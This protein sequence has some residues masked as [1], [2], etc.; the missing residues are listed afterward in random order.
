MTFQD[1][2]NNF[3]TI[4]MQK[5]FCFEGRSGR[6]EFWMW[7][8]ALLLID[9]VYNVIILKLFPG[10]GLYLGRIFELVI[11]CPSLG[12][13]ARRLH[14]TGKTGLLQLIGLVFPIGV[15]IILILCAFEGDKG[16]NAYGAPVGN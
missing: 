3:K 4:F 5:Y 14:D 7:V 8:L 10:L 2:V 12:V 16:S 6:R 1:L 15:I 13:T 11:L 9:I